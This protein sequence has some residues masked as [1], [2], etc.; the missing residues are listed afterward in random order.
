MK[1]ENWYRVPVPIHDLMGGGGL[2]G[3]IGDEWELNREEQE[4]E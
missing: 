4:Q 1:I 3:K 2:N